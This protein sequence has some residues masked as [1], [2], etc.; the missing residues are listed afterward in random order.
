MASVI[1]DATSGVGEQP[2][3]NA[4]PIPMSFPAILRAPKLADRFAHL[5]LASALDNPTSESARLVVKKN[6]REERE[7]KRW[8][9]RKENCMFRWLNA[10]AY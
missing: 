3:A 5:R 6:K 7:G 1:S 9:R 2:V 10:A 8:I 4:G